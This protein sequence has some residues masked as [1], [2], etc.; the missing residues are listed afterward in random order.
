MKEDFDYSK[1]NKMVRFP[2]GGIQRI[3]PEERGD[4]YMPKENV[5]KDQSLPENEKTKKVRMILFVAGIA[6]V[7]MAL[8]AISAYLAG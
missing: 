1:A 5:E 4:F 8:F 6:L 3:T 7:A 2:V